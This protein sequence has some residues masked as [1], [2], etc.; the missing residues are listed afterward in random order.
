MTKSFKGTFRHSDYAEDPPVAGSIEDM[1][2]LFRRIDWTAAM[3]EHA[4]QQTFPE[5]IVERIANGDLFNLQF[6]GPGD[7]F[8]CAAIVT[9][10]KPFLGMDIW[11][12][13]ER[14]ESDEIELSADAAI[15]ALAAFGA[16]DTKQLRG[17]WP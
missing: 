12:F 6:I 16:G 9:I 13:R 5:L 15:G 17:L 14:W 2:S 7:I 11:I 4:E 10:P 1:I 3:H 8:Q